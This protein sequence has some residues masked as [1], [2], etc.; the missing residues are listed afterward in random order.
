[1]NKQ[2]SKKNGRETTIAKVS[3]E[4]G[5]FSLTCEVREPYSGPSDYADGVNDQDKQYR[6]VCCG[7]MGEELLKTFPTLSKIEPMHL[8]NTSTGE[9]MHGEANGRYWLGGYL[10]AFG[11]TD[12]TYGP[13]VE[14]YK[15]CQTRT[16][17][18]C[19]DILAEH[20]RVPVTEVEALAKAITDKWETEGLN[21]PDT[22]AAG[23]RKKGIANA[24]WVKW[25]ADQLP[26]MKQEAIETLAFIEAM[27]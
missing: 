5:H 13:T 4:R 19:R 17:E 10:T 1:M 7:A 3:T 22:M 12:D 8:A 14:N 18:Q 20:V 16:P 21:D 24:I 6:I 23:I 26:R 25:Y 9:P 15:D 11:I 27:K 2:L